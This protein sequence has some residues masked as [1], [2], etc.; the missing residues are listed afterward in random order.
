LH[1]HQ[2]R[3]HVSFGMLMPPPPPPAADAI[4]DADML[5]MLFRY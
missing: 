4:D 1:S 5:F 2:R 3:H